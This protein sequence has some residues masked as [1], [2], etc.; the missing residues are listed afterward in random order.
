MEAT[1]TVIGNG[2]LT[3]YRIGS[4]VDELINERKPQR[5]DTVVRTL[6]PDPIG[7]R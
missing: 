2:G 6:D 7:G 5:L 1:G 4:S 3:N